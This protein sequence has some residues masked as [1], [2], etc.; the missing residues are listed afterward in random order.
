MKRVGAAAALLLTLLVAAPTA[1]YEAV[2][3]T[4]TTNYLALSSAT[5]KGRV[6]TSYLLDVGAH[7]FAL[8][9]TGGRFY[10]CLSVWQERDG[11]VIGRNSGC[12]FEATQTRLRFDGS[13]RAVL[14]Q[15]AITLDR[16]AK[17]CCLAGKTLLVEAVAQPSEDLR[18]YTGCLDSRSGPLDHASRHAS[19][20]GTLTIRGSTAAASG[21]ASQYVFTAECVESA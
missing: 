16:G 20:A 14:A 13:F 10:V 21:T 3:V 5:T 2:V 19:M 17:G 15:T 12:S 6:T 4:G 1:A 8:A 9:G 11:V 7:E 18:Q